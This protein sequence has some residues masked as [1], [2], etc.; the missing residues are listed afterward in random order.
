V[1][2]DAP[3]VGA[4]PQE[5][6]RVLHTES[7][8]LLISYRKKGASQ[9]SHLHHVLKN[10]IT[11]HNTIQ[12]NHHDLLDRWTTPFF[13]W[14]SRHVFYVTTQKAIKR[15]TAW[16]EYLITTDQDSMVAQIQSVV[17]A[18]K[19]PP[20]GEPYEFWSGDIGH[21]DP[22]FI[23]RFVSED[24]YI[25]KGIVTTSAVHYGAISIGPAGGLPVSAIEE[26]E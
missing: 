10:K 11:D 13:Y 17:F 25:N 2:D 23:E 21:A 3:D 1:V 24:A 20:G 5:E 12:P 8:T 16:D 19:L 18:K 14:D 22:A 15:V 9:Y 6:R 7:D 4:L 26:E